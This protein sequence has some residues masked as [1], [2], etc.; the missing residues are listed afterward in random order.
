MR[1]LI[2]FI[3]NATNEE[4]NNYLS[5]NGYT[6]VKQ[7][8]N[9]DKVYLVD[10]ANVPPASSL[11]ERYEE[12]NTIAL[13]PH[14]Y[15][16]ICNPYHQTHSDPAQQDIVINTN[17]EKDWWKNFSYHQPKFEEETYTIKRLGDNITVYIMDSGIQRDH[18]EFV[19]ADINLLYTVTPNDFADHNGHGTALAGIIVG[20]TCGITNAKVQ[21]VKIFDQNH[22][23]TQSEFLD[24]LDAILENHVD[25]TFGVINCSWSIPKNEWIEHKL[26]LAVAEGMYVIAAAG[27]TGQPI[28]NVTPASM[29]EALTVGAYDQNLEPCNFSDYT[30]PAPTGNDLTNHGELDGWAPGVQIWSAV[31]NSTCGY[32]SGTSMSAAITSAVVI[33]NLSWLADENGQRYKPYESRQLSTISDNIDGQVFTA[34]RREDLLDLQDPKY[35]NSKNRIATIFDSSLNVRP[36]YP[37]EITTIWYL[38]RENKMAVFSPGITKKLSL[39]EPL[40]SGFEFTQNGLLWAIPSPEL[41]PKPGEHYSTLAF[42]MI[43]TDINDF[44]EQVSVTIHIMEQDKDVTEIPSDDPIIP[45]T[46]L[47]ICGGLKCVV[48]S[49]TGCQTINCDYGCCAGAAKS[50]GLQCRCDP[51]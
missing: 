19:E 8:N 26:A 10:G 27:N 50:N 28:D 36:Q 32:F 22:S 40:P 5:E 41:G 12:E 39:A 51:G 46:L 42:N 24:A 18:L 1:Y 43:R 7:W 48:G 45:I 9:F 2:D 34:F 6:V 20:K 31:L 35:A 30:G 29:M 21:V 23:T 11:V 44:D 13:T 47:A 14:A 15:D 16:F 17:D 37:D 3:N 33:T 38:G 4:I 25:N 49:T